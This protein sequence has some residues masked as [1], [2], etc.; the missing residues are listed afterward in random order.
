MKPIEE[1]IYLA[2]N[3]ARQFV[4]TGPLEDSDVYSDAL[5]GLVLA[6]QRMN[7]D[8]AG[9]TTLACR[10]IKNQIIDGI[11]Q[12]NRQNRLNINSEEVDVPQQEK[13]DEQYA[14]LFL[15]DEFLNDPTHPYRDR[16]NVEIAKK[17]YVDGMT[18]TDIGK[19]IK[20]SRTMAMN[21]GR[22]GLEV[23]KNKMCE[24]S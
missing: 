6:K 16:R 9:F 11:R 5:M 24:I 21:Y 4:P 13:N 12:R 15:V 19:K 23:I 2:K 7:E 22:I 20:V 8:K 14:A 3:V 18:W 1:Y 17:H 10:C